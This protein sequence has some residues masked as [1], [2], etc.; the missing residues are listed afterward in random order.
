M[1][2]GAGGESH[3]RITTC[4]PAASELVLVAW[5]PVVDM[6]EESVVVRSCDKRTESRLGAS[7]RD[8][9]KGGIPA[10]SKAKNEPETT[11]ESSVVTLENLTEAIPD[12]LGI[13]DF[14]RPDKG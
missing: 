5:F 13:P 14:F 7:D 3:Y 9:E 10:F 6:A 8:S 2:Q 4:F 11:V 12:K 1:L